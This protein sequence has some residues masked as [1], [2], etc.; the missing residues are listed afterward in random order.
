MKILSTGE[1]SKRGTAIL[2]A[3]LVLAT[4]LVPFSLNGNSAVAA[5]NPD[6]VV[7]FNPLTKASIDGS[8]LEGKASV[9]D[10]VALGFT[11]DA[12][13]ANPQPGQS[14]SIEFPTAFTNREPGLRVPLNHKGTD[15][16]ECKIEK[17][18]IQCS[19]NDAI[20]G[21]TDIK[22]TATALMV[23]VQATDE[24]NANFVV[25]GSKVVNV[26]LPAGQPIGPGRPHVYSPVK[27][28]KSTTPFGVAHKTINW[29]VAFDSRAVQASTGVPADGVTRQT[30]VIEDFLSAG[31][32][33]K[34][35][36]NNYAEFTLTL[37]DSKTT[38]RPAPRPVLT[39]GNGT[40]VTTKYGD[41]DLT[42]EKISPTAAIIK[43]TGPF[44]PDTNYYM[45]YQSEFTSDNKVVAPGVLYMNDSHI[46]GT[47]LVAHAERGYYDSFSVTVEMQD[48]FGSFKGSKTLVGSGVD[49]VPSDQKYTLQV[50]YTLPDGKNDAEYP[51]WT[52]KPTSNPFTIEVSAGKYNQPD[53]VFPIGTVLTITEPTKPNV[54]GVNWGNVKMT[55]KDGERALST[56]ADTATVTIQNQKSL[57]VVVEN[58]AIDVP[59]YSKFSVTKRIAGL[60]E[61]QLGGNNTFTF[62]YRCA[63]GTT[64]QIQVGVGATVQSENVL[65]DDVCVISERK[66]QDPAGFRASIEAPK[67]VV[68]K[69]GQVVDVEFTNTYKPVAKFS[70]T[71]TV[72]GLTGGLQVPADQKFH[73]A[74]VCTAVEGQVVDPIAGDLE[75]AA[76]ATVEGPEVPVGYF[77]RVTEKNT[78]AAPVWT[79]ANW[80]VTTPEA[81]TI[82]VAADA[83]NNVVTM[84]NVY[85]PQTAKFFVA[86]TV[87]GLPQDITVPATEKFTF[88]YTCGTETGEIQVAAGDSVAGPAVPVGTVCQI[89]EKDGAWKPANWD[90]V[91]PQAQDLTIKKSA[92][93][94]VVTFDN[95]YVQ[96]KGKFSV[97]K[98]LQGVEAA[99]LP[100]NQEFTFNYT[101]TSGATG[102]IVVAPGATGESKELNVGDSCEITEVEPTEKPAGFSWTAPAAQTAV[103]EK[104]TVVNKTFVNVYTQQM[105]KFSVTKSLEGLEAA[106]LPAGHKF[107]FSYTCGD[108]EGTLQVGAGETVESKEI[109][110]GATCTITE[111]KP[112]GHP[113]HFDIA[114]PDAQQVVVEFGKVNNVA[115]KNVYNRPLVKFS[116]SKTVS[117]LTDGVMPAGQ[118]FAFNYTCGAETGVLQV[119]AGGSVDGPAV[120]AGTVCKVE[121]AP[122]AWTPDGWN[123]V[124]P[125]A[126]SLN[127]T[128]DAAANT[129]AFDNAYTQ[130]MAKFSVTKTVTGI[131]ADQLPAG[132]EFT[133][134]YTCGAT[135][136]ELKA[137]AGAT[138]E[139]P[140][141][142]VGTECVIT[143]A[144]PADV[145]GWDVTVPAAKTITIAKDATA[146]TAAFENVYVQKKGKFTVTKEVKGIEAAMVTDKDFKFEYTCGTEPKQVLTVRAGATVESPELVYGTECTVT[147]VKE[148][149]EIAGAELIALTAAQTVTIGDEPKVELTFVNEYKVKPL[150]LDKDKDKVK[151][152][153]AL[154]QTGAS[155]AGIAVAAVALLALGFGLRRV[156][157]FN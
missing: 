90:L 58:E 7:K 60:Q 103:V 155:V 19:F 78:D 99:Q 77:C 8:A 138:V 68:V 41:F 83:T 2:T 65:V 3:V 117:G 24:N 106:D 91:K 61:A 137:A 13:N 59:V 107:D 105:S 44:Q 14:F 123:L 49:N 1:K 122:N 111:Q 152:P 16:G 27:F 30:L 139:G 79:P 125:P 23:A 20:R 115:F 114:T 157:K 21:K 71:K 102:S 145:A 35:E 86:K 56:T 18:R 51:T 81:K 100:T 121:E 43:V 57:A 141:V 136:G 143:E 149:T 85:A 130:Q 112:T 140:E 98:N 96:Q 133:F 146:N 76:G 69:N 48:G 25:N 22:G 119:P 75:V 104:D 11:W 15:V 66:P 72:T 116:V 134:N 156:R 97:T 151:T 31:Q 52:Q 94:N 40:D 73:F 38:L 109:K 87:S 154:P 42:V 10:L 135:T 9:N 37:G 47:D 88:T 36:E 12:T 101:C 144:K 120:P 80:D 34:G 124:V 129:V 108:V 50:Q 6:I 17:T 45:I 5:D 153:S 118:T 54:A 127:I 28:V 150:S 84:E 39:R 93:D 63:S 70:V 4:M 62:D 26:A 128:K 95:A 67:T 33:F 55:V 64:G 53:L 113:D 148:S 131:A 82:T 32:V 132:T 74:Y 142:P 110:V 147:E 89:S 126:K 46:Q 92:A 29:E